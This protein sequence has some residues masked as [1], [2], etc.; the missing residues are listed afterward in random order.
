[1][2]NAAGLAADLDDR[3]GFR[4]AGSTVRRLLVLDPEDRRFAVREEDHPVPV[5]PE[6]P[7]LAEIRPCASTSLPSASF[8]FGC[9]D[10][11]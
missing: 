10:R 3:R 4:C 9:F 2:G 11:E 5:G 1:M 7:E 8:H 6:E